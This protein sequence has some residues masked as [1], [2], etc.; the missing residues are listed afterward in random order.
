MNILK[1]LTFFLFSGTLWAVSPTPNTYGE[2]KLLKCLASEELLLYQNNSTGPLYKLNQFFIDELSAV[3]EFSPKASF[4]PSI[5]RS[6][7]YSPSVSLLRLMLLEGQNIFDTGTYDGRTQNYYIQLSLIKSLVD[8]APAIF[9]DYILN[10]QA[11]SP[12]AG[13]LNQRIP[14]LAKFTERYKN[15]ESEK[16]PHEL[17]DKKE[18]EAIFN[19]LKDYDKFNIECER[20]RK[21]RLQKKQREA[22][23]PVTAQSKK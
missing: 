19:K 9:F 21:E 3:D 22:M 5:C 11:K 1:L 16:L 18:I 23:P 15:L 7:E 8:R 6:K 14:E 4:L 17:V 13:C 10:L 12:L 2:N 20:V